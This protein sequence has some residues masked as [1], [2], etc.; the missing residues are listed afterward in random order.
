[1]K[2]D[3]LPAVETLIGEWARWMRTESVGRG[4]PR[5][6]SAMSTGG[7]SDDFDDLCDRAD[8]ARAQQMDACIRSLPAG[9][10]AAVHSVW[11]GSRWVLDWME[12]DACYAQALLQLPRICSSRG[13]VL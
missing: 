9:P 1:M 12:R 13:V 4:Y 5:R 2:A 3:D 10:C 11:L 8:R 7:A 6:V